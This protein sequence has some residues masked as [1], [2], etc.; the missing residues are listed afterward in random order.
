MVTLMITLH[1]N[2]SFPNWI[3]FV[4]IFPA[5]TFPTELDHF[6]NLQLRQAP[7][8]EYLPGQPY[9]PNKP[10]SNTSLSN[11][12]VRLDETESWRN[13]CT[14]LLAKNGYA[15]QENQFNKNRFNY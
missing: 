11:N 9:K 7:K 8:R 5:N 3:K 15:N 10:S 6:A 13:D 12:F 1:T 4:T 14:F 2:I